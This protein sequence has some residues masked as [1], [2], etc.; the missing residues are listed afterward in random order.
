MCSYD[1]F[2]SAKYILHENSRMFTGFATE[3]GT[4][5]YN[6]VPMGIKNACSYSRRKLQE[7]LAKNSVL[8]KAGVKNY[9]DDVPIAA[10]SEEEF[11]DILKNLLDICREAKLKLN[12]EKSILGVDSI[13]LRVYC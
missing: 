6:R 5:V 11:L 13:T 1:E 10:D 12:K 4:F 9:F 7:I 2:L 3:D 8:L